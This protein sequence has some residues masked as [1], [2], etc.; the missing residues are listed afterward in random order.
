MATMDTTQADKMLND[1]AVADPAEAPDIA[2]ELAAE[3][4]EKLEASSPP[5]PEEETAEEAP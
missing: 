1:L 3:L 2:D 4:T 5:Q